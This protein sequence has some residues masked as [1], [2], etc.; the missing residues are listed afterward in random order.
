M[1]L[2]WEEEES[3]G[4]GSDF[5]LGWLARVNRWSLVGRFWL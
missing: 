1:P 4:T 2:M 3:V 5:G